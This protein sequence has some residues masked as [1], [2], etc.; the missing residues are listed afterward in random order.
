MLTRSKS[1]QLLITSPHALI[2]SL[3]PS[4]IH[5]A[6]LDSQWVC[7]M[8]EEF[9]ALQRNHTWELVPFSKDMNLIGC[10][11]V[12]RVKYNPN[13]TILKHKTRLVAKGFLQNP[14]INY[15]ETFSPVVKAP[16]IRV[17]F[18]LAVT[19]GWD[20]QQ[21]DVNNT[22]LNGEL[23]E[24]VFMSQPEGFISSR[25]PSHVCR[26]KKSL[27]GLKQAPRAWYTK[28]RGALQS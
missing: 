24:E 6:L 8:K 3:E 28:L 13:G 4:T 14:G 10:K 17:L 22:F 7:A 5:E 20:I 11:W 25:Y 26:L 12:F 2:S 23:E 9:S 15:V 1:K 21:V 16:T 18:S 19:Y 27:Y